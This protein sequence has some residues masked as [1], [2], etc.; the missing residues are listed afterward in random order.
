MSSGQKWQLELKSEN[1]Q[2]L[3]CIH[4][5]LLPDR[6][7]N[8]LGRSTGHL[9]ESAG[10]QR[11]G[12]RGFGLAK[13]GSLDCNCIACQNPSLKCGTERPRQVE[14]FMVRA[15]DWIH[16]R[17]DIVDVLTDHVRHVQSD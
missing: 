10:G 15:A 9:A 8:T 3:S 1:L 16:Q 5:S 17:I 11:T 2:R 12:V 7:V 6:G 14:R 13:F 4:L